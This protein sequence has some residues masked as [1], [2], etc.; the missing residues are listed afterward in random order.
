MTADDMIRTWAA[1]R[2]GVPVEQV[3]CV[4]F[5]HE[6][7]W[8]NDSGTWWP[9]DNTATAIV[10][11]E[12]K[13]G[14]KHRR[15]VHVTSAYGFEEVPDLLREIMEACQEDDAGLDSGGEKP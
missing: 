11:A 4:R 3:E 5:D 2:I 6:D 13:R 12:G 1:K 8:G 7:A 15:K 10:I 14:Q 9:E